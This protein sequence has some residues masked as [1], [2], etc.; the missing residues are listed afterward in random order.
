MDIPD[1][2]SAAARRSLASVLLTSVAVTAHHLYT[3]GPGAWVLGAVLALGPAGLW[4]WYRKTGSRVAW[5]GYLAMNAWIVVGF[6]L[7]SGLWDNALRL[8]LGTFLAEVSTSFAPPFIG[9]FGYEAS[10][11][12]TLFGSLF[13][14]ANGVR[15]GLAERRAARPEAPRRRLSRRV[16][17]SLAAASAIGVAG[18]FAIA[19][20]DGW[21]APANGVV[22]I[23]VV[24]PTSGPYAILGTSFLR[25]AQMAQADLRGTRYRYELAV[26]DSGPDPAGARG[27]IE[28]LVREEKVDAIVGGISLI[29]Q[30][31]QPLATAARIPHVCVCTVSSI[32]DG[33][34][35]FTN[36]P[37]P[38]AEARLWVEEARR[39]GIASVAL[40]TQDYPSIVNH[41]KAL[42]TE[43]ERGGLR[44]VADEVFGGEV[45][46]FTGAIARSRGASPDVF[47]VEALE[48]GL[49]RLAGQ[50][51]AAGIH[52]L[53]SVVA[54]SVSEHPELF[55]GVWY[56]D[57]NL[58]DAGFRGRFEAQY[59][60]ARFATHMM[61]YAYDAVNM[62]VEAYE[63]GENPAVHLRNMR[64]YPGTAGELVKAPGSGNFQ[65]AP[66]VWTIRQGRPTLAATISG[67][68][69]F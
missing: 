33:G 20:Y 40:L 11:L 43:A 22:T 45:S 12:L 39:R 34:Y 5:H 62:I 28:R 61:P 64:R 2:R 10:S 55:E 44:I 4:A 37:S 58:L 46:D 23:G 30:V 59:P 38:Q 63:R 57:S 67:P 60:G 18:A 47:Y 42:K 69:S 9:T 3:L 7:K 36:I 53:A 26:I 17:V 54:P 66:A 29:G 16:V 48:P 13:V 8:F 25:A 56:T 1:A 24:I 14:L 49:D 65:S 27:K 68:T 51:S 35:N 15:F 32:G 41:V 6:G 21:R 19:D 31:T 52:N 50:M